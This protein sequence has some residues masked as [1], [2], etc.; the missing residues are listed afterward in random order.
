SLSDVRAARGLASLAE[1]L[2]RSDAI[3]LLHRAFSDGALAASSGD[4]AQIVSAVDSLAAIGLTLATLA[5]GLDSY[6]CNVYLQD[7]ATASGFLIERLESDSALTALPVDAA[8]AAEWQSLFAAVS[9]A[10]PNDARH[11]ERGLNAIQQRAS[12]QQT[13]GAAESAVA[14]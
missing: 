6:S 11:L 5:K 12:A 9:T 1:Y 3:A 10:A 4:T 7:V 8:V 13:F 14:Q 2:E